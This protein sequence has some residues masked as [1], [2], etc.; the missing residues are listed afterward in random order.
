M[1]PELAALLSPRRGHFQLGS[2]LHGDLWLDVSR[3]FSRASRIAPLATSLASRL[4]DVEVVCGPMPGGGLLAQ[5]VAAELDVEFCYAERLANA[6]Y[7]IPPALGAGLRGKTVAVVDDVIYRGSAVNRTLTELAAFDAQPV[8]VGA[9]LVLQSPRRRGTPCP[10]TRSMWTI[11]LRP[12]SLS[13]A[14]TSEWT[15][16]ACPRCA[17]GIPLED[18]QGGQESAGGSKA[19]TRS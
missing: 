14:D 1:L 5:L 2:G 12:E 6:E 11:G 15:P 13:F 4:S 9:L 7:R 3:L 19:P 17:F 18:V 16:S 8:V 10:W